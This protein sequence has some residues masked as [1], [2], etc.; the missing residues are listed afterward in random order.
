MEHNGE[1][2]RT[3]KWDFL[4]PF[5][6]MYKRILGFFF[7]FFFSQGKLWLRAKWSQLEKRW[8]QQEA[9]SPGP[10]TSQFCADHMRPYPRSAVHSRSSEESLPGSGR[11]SGPL[12]AQNS[13]CLGSHSPALL[14]DLAVQPQSADRGKL[15]TAKKKSPHCWRLFP[16]PLWW[17]EGKCVGFFHAEVV[18]VLELLKCWAT[19]MPSDR[20]RHVTRLRLTAAR[21][22]RGGFAI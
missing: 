18:E 19:A 2:N 1:A 10:N 13:S 17:E 8:R 7:F 6:L 12:L 11:V 15:K 16:C 20:K 5:P 21:N 4:V 3:L 14:L 9:C 22:I